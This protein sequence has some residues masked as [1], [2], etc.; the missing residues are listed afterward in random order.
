MLRTGA[1]IVIAPI[2]FF[3][4]E[5]NAHGGLISYDISQVNFELGANSEANSDW[6]HVTFTYDPSPGIQYFNLTMNGRWAA[7]N[8]PVSSNVGVDVGHQR[9]VS[10]SLGN[11]VGTDVTSGVF[12]ATLMPEPLSVAPT[13]GSTLVVADTAVTVG[14][15]N[16][17]PGAPGTAPTLD[18]TGFGPVGRIR[19]SA[20]IDG[21]HNQAAGVDECGPAA[22]SNSI[23][24]LNDK[25]HLGIPPNK[26]DIPAMKTATNWRA[27]T[28]QNGQPVP[29]TGGTSGDFVGGKRAAVAQWV[30]TTVVLPTDPGFMDTIF[31][32]V[33]EGCD[34]EI[35]SRGHIATVT[36]LVQGNDDSWSID[37]SHDV[38]Q[39]KPGGN[40]VETIKFD[41]DIDRI[42]R[43]GYGFNLKGFVI[44]CPVPEPGAGTVLVVLGTWPLKRPR[45]GTLRRV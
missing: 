26:F 42:A 40:E 18:F 41:P 36:G 33:A 29:G 21:M 20:Y 34:V 4:L 3:V 16:E 35:L 9:G 38:M 31:N 7:I 19:R 6:G 13:G 25:Y 11:T 15:L 14:S 23:W 1:A 43:G 2:L 30:T 12:Q 10:F 24:Y 5:G 37:V 27:P 22:F 8:V 17:P 45:R 44:E 28:V 32:A 39:G